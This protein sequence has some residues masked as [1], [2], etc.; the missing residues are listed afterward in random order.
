MDLDVWMFQEVYRSRTPNPNPYPTDHLARMKAALPGCEGVFFAYSEAEFEKGVAIVW[1]AGRFDAIGPPMGHRWSETGL[2]TTKGGVA[3]I[4]RRRSDSKEFLVACVHLAA[5]GIA[6][7]R[8]KQAREAV[9]LFRADVERNAAYL[10]V[11]PGDLPWILGGDLNT[12]WRTA[13]GAYG[14]LVNEAGFVPATG[15][16]VRTHESGLHLDH[17]LHRGMTLLEGGVRHDV[18]SSDHYPLFARF[19]LR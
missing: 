18:R 8:E 5:S 2:D 6:G 19:D 4:L 10:G 13:E 14:Y 9:A 15:S 7:P 1:D 3:Q 12:V 16:T 17:L 11:P